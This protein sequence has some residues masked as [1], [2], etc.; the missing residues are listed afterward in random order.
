MARSA[1]EMAR[2]RAEA[3]VRP[4]ISCTEARPSISTRCCFN[5]ASTASCP[6]ARLPHWRDLGQKLVKRPASP[7]LV[8]HA[9]HSDILADPGV[10]QFQ[11]VFNLIC[12]AMRHGPIVDR[13]GGVEAKSVEP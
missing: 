12:E 5:S 10:A 9:A 13:K 4:A 1:A 8:F 7:C 2:I 11:I 3:R 6:S